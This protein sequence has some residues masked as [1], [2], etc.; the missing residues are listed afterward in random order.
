MT[1]TFVTAFTIGGLRGEITQLN[2]FRLRE[3][4]SYR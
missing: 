2:G 1:M 4:S 3:P